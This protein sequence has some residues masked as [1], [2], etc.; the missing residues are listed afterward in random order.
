MFFVS[1]ARATR[2]LFVGLR[3]RS[4]VE[5]VSGP[6]DSL[7]IL[8]PRVPIRPLEAPARPPWRLWSTAFAR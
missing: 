3:P 2:A 6:S 4:P 8:F 1:Q 7:V 5:C